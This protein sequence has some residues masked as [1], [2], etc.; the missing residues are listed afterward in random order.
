MREIVEYGP[1]IELIS[2]RFEEM[3]YWT[4]RHK[5]KKAANDA[6]Q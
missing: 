5:I 4:G 2:L 3:G 1:Q 6:A